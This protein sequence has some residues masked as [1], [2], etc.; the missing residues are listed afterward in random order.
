[1]VD[2]IENL[3]NLENIENFEYIER[4]IANPTNDVIAKYNTQELEEIKEQ[5]L[6]DVPMVA[7]RRKELLR[8]LRGYRYVDELSEL[9]EGVYTRWIPLEA[10]YAVGGSEGQSGGRR[11]G[12]VKLTTGGIL[13]DIRVTESGVALVCK[14]GMGRFFQ[15]R[16]ETSLVFQKLTDQEKVILYAMDALSLS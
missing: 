5:I 2:S 14:N 12:D 13:C 15:C 11:S 1:M 3:E 6:G 7:A 9:K 8:T 10:I 16:M 4:A